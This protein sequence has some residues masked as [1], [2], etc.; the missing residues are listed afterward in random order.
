M[1]YGADGHITDIYAGAAEVRREYDSDNHMLSE[2]YFDET[3]TPYML[4]GDYASMRCEYDALGNL[5]TEAFFG[6]DGKPV[7]STKG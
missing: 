3:G 4:R 1:Y 6:T 2:E 7:I 5:L